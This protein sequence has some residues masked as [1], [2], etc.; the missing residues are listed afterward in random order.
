MVKRRAHA[1]GKS[2]SVRPISRK[3]PPW[4]RY[5]PEE[6]K[7]LVIKLGKDMVPPSLIGIILR[8][9]HG[10]PLVKQIVGKSVAQILKEHNLAP[11]IPSDLASLTAKAVKLARHM[12]RHK[13]DSVNKH[14]L[15]RLEAKIYHLERYYK[16]TGLLP[17]GWGYKAVVLSA[18]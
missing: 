1:H 9:Q 2:H 12:E 4:C 7:A 10:I 8:D 5:E 15:Q 6:V 3:A 16:K 14:A 17:S 18:K 13:A 11:A